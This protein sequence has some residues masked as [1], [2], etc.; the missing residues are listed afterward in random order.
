M[1]RPVARRL[2]LADLMIL[3]AMTGV[4]LSCYVFVDNGLFH[5][6]RYLFGLFDARHVGGLAADHVTAR[7]VWSRSCSSFL[8]DGRSPFRC[9]GAGHLGWDG[10]DVAAA[11]RG[12]LRRGP[13]RDGLRDGDRRGPLWYSAGGLM[14]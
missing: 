7:S 1:S 12:G 8:V 9:C 6:Q 3:V 11:R 5:G 4:G 13:G 2:S 10:V 14:G